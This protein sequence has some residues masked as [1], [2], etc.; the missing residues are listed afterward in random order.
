MRIRLFGLL[1]VAGLV[2]ASLAR[3]AAQ[4]VP[5]TPPPPIPGATSSPA[6][7]QI[8]IGAPPTAAPTAAPTLTP[9]PRRGRGTA[10]PATSAPSPGSSPSETPAPPQFTTLDG[11]WELEAQTRMKT[12]YS[13]ISLKQSGQ[14]GS[15][16]TGVWDRDNKKLPITGTFDG[17][18]FKFTATDGTKQYTLSG[19]VENFSDMVGLVIDGTGQMAFTGQHRK[20]EKAF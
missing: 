15:E 20:R 8:P 14:A 11:T 1:A 17:R 19:Y 13:H 10:A 6:G 9:A 12:Y 7:V 3:G 4:S 16:I 2:F 5:P 18:L